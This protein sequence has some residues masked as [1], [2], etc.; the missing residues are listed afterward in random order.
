MPV[1]IEP[2][3]GE[4]E[5]KL[6]V[7][8]FAR[9]LVVARQKDGSAVKGREVPVQVTPLAARMIGRGTGPLQAAPLAQAGGGGAGHVAGAAGRHLDKL[10][11]HLC[12][13]GVVKTLEAERAR[14]TS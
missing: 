14:E 9:L 5:G 11:P 10:V 8:D 1:G 7:G 4:H 13:T 6:V 3:G 12:R 2:A